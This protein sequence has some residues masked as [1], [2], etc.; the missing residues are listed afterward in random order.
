MW[1]ILV[2]GFTPV[3]YKVFTI[4]AGI[5]GMSVIPFILASIVGRGARFFLVAG[6]IVFAGSY[7]NNDEDLIQVIRRYIDLA[8]WLVIGLV[9]ILILVL[10]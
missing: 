5:L 7:F 10:L 8:G 9:V 1:V 2:A 4:T 6:L 3:P